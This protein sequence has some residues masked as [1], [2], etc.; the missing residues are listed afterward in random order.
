MAAGLV[1]RPLTLAAI[2]NTQVVGFAP[3]RRV[4][5]VDFGARGPLATANGATAEPITAVGPE[6]RGQRGPAP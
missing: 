6:A 4:T 2:L 3:T 5:L 1:D